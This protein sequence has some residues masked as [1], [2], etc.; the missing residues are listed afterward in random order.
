[1]VVI[2]CEKF[3][4]S[5]I[6]SEVLDLHRFATTAHY[7]GGFDLLGNNPVMNFFI[8]VPLKVVKLA[9]LF[10]TYGIIYLGQLKRPEMTYLIFGRIKFTKFTDFTGGME[11]TRM[12]HWVSFFPLYTMKIVVSSQNVY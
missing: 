12:I 8:D 10:S 7:S 11:M 1:M 3:L 2:G 5:I 9:V 4:L 6:T